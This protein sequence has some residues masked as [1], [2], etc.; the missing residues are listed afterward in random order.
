[1]AEVIYEPSPNWGHCGLAGVVYV[2]GW[3]YDKQFP[4]KELEV[5]SIPLFFSTVSVQ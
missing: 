2:P 3:E 1:M 4:P 5:N